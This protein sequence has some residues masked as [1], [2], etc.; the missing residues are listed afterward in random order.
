MVMR[1]DPYERE[2]DR[3]AGRGDGTTA[4]IVL[5]VFLLLIGLGT[6]AFVYLRD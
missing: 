4:G 2:R 6:I 3:A 1:P 5:T